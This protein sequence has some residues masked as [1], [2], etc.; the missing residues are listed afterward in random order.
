MQNKPKQSQQPQPSQ[1]SPQAP[2][3]ELDADQ[4]AV[5]AGGR[6]GRG[7]GRTPN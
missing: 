6:R 1:P 5:V 4:L 7:P 3:V 2:I